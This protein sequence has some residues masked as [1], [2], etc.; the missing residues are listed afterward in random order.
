MVPKDV[1][2]EV[3][4]RLTLAPDGPQGARVTVGY[5]SREDL[6]RAQQELAKFPENERSTYK[7]IKAAAKAAGLPVVDS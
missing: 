1:L 5:N 3:S 6:A 4:K 7:A 2:T